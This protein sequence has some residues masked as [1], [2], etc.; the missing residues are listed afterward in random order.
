MTIQ[1]EKASRNGTP[2]PTPPAAAANGT[3]GRAAVRTAAANRRTSR[4]GLL[5][6]VLVIALGG[7]IAFTA[8]QM[9]TQRSKVLVVA[10]NVAVGEVIAADDLTV[11][12][13]TKDP[14][15]SSVPEG[16]LDNVVGQIAQVRLVKGAMLAAGQYGP[17]SGFVAGQVQVALPLAVG[18]LPS[19]GLVPGQKVLVVATPGR[20]GVG[21]SDP[22][23]GIP[24]GGIQATVA[25]VG[26]TNDATQTTVVDVQVP[27]ES[28]VAVAKLASTGNLAVILLPDQ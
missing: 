10:Q 7:V 3:P 15:L 24:D 8:A 11:A 22:I 21:T 5:I 17:S 28:G 23:T 9:L 18:Q 19:R 2:P 12:N 16:D 4:R 6:S 14:A 27:T 13:V 20:S 26:A 25:N 1:S